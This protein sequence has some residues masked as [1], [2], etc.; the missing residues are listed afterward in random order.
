MSEQNITKERWKTIAVQRF[1]CQVQTFLLD[2]VMSCGKPLDKI[3]AELEL[4]EEQLFDRLMDSEDITMRWIG[5]ICAVTTGQAPEILF[6]S[7]SP[8]ARAIVSGAV[9]G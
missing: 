5:E 2:A 3:A 6:K 1:I 9:A 4:T 7:M 8:E